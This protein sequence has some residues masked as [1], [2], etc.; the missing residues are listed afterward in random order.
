LSLDFLRRYFDYI[1]PVAVVY[2]SSEQT[3]KPVR[4]FDH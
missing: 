1:R 3:S 2:M 4:Y